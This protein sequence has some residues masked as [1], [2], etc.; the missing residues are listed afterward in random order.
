MATPLKRAESSEETRL[1]DPRPETWLTPAEMATI[2]EISAGRA[3]E[4]EWEALGGSFWLLWRDRGSDRL[5]SLLASRR[6]REAVHDYAARLGVPAH[7]AESRFI[8]SP[9]PIR[10][11]RTED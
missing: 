7:V 3:G 11:E 5:A 2:G 8:G 10:S 6:R 9:T 4:A 1:A